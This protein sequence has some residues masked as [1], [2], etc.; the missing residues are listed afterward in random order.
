MVEEMNETIET[1]NSAYVHGITDPRKAMELIMDKMTEMRPRREVLLKPYWRQTMYSQ[2]GL[3]GAVKL[4]MNIG[5]PEAETG[6]VAYAASW[7]WAEQE[8]EAVIN[9]RGK[10]CVWLGEECIYDTTDSES[11]MVIPVKL[12]KGKNELL[13]RC[14]KQKESWGIELYVSCPRYPFMWARD[15]L[16]NVRCTL[17]FEE[18]E[19]LEGFAFLGA[20]PRISAPIG[21]IPVIY[22]GFHKGTVTYRWSPAWEEEKE[23]EKEADFIQMYGGGFPFCV[24]ALTYCDTKEGEAYLLEL[25]CGGVFKI[26]LDGEEVRESAHSGKCLFRISG[27][28][29]TRQL[30]IKTAGAL[31]N[32]TFKGRI[33]RE[34]CQESSI[35][36]IP[37]LKAGKDR[38]VDWIYVGPFR[39]NRDTEPELL[40]D[41]PFAPE[42]EIQ[43]KTPYPLGNFEKGFWRMAGK[44]IYIR[45]YLDT[46]FFGQWFYAVQVGLYGLFT[47]ARALSD[48]ERMRYFLDSIQVMADYFDYSVWDRQQFGCPVMLPRACGLTELDPCG[49]IGVS[50]IEAYL[51]TGNEMQ[52]RVIRMLAEIVMD[53]LLTFGDNTYYRGTTMWADDFYMSC[54]FLV[55]AARLTG[56]EK[57]ADRAMAQVRGFVKRL[58]MPDKKLFSHIYFTEKTCPNRIPWGRG[59]GWMAVAL[60]ELLLFL[61]QKEWR[62]EVLQVYREFMEGILCVQDGDGMWHQVLDMP[63]TYEETSCTGMFLLSFIR[64]IKNGW[65]EKERYGGAVS[66]A[67]NAL[68]QKGIDK[69]GNVYGVC[70]GS[71]CSMEPSYYSDIPTHKNDDHGTGIL[72]MAAAELMTLWEG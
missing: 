44:D 69:D 36:R 48:S 8:A 67:W 59:N 28:G 68:L 11:W 30:L 55:R 56:E 66:R 20:F 57:Y 34:A 32:Y 61:K 43:F 33:C 58:Y 24:Y 51:H 41:I 23:K 64:G 7:L 63:E 50:M 60:T 38:Q 26:F 9:L 35:Q 25:E 5:Y 1:G 49:T 40:L 47:A 13:A 45:P 53:R 19:G 3:F 6:N 62:E 12:K 2:Q 14:T 10:G 72:L 16:L 17:P 42:H 4:D 37:S 71:G 21:R 54:P 27:N 18:M 39:E 31:E 46:I 65:L 15:Y 22:S 52:L 29:K 70:M